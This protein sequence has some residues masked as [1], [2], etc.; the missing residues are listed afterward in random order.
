MK[1]H[2]GKD[3]SM[4]IYNFIGRYL[5]SL[6]FLVKVDAATFTSQVKSSVTGQETKAQPRTGL[7]QNATP[8]DQPKALQL[9]YESVDALCLSQ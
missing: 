8:F 9:S 4:Y 5:I 7:L 3:N 6:I 2:E 1:L